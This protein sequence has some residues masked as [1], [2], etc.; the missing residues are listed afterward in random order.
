VLRALNRLLRPG[1]RLAFFTIFVA[2]GL[3]PAARRRARRSGPRAV[4]TRSDHQRLLA[5]AGFVDIDERDATAEF[6]RTAR[7]WIEE[8]DRHADEL[9]AVESASVF[10]ERRRNG[11]VQLRAVEDGL[12]RRALFTARRR[13]GRGVTRDAPVSS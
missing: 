3:A 13:P 7:A 6:A 4:A 2:P 11:R 9:R 1:G 5:G 8:R 10:D 12:L